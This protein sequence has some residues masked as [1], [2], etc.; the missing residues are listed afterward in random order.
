MNGAQAEK[1]AEGILEYYSL[2][3][4]IKIKYLND[5]EKPGMWGEIQN[6]NRIYGNYV[7]GFEKLTT[8]LTGGFLSNAELRGYYKLVTD[9]YYTTE[10]FS[11]E[12]VGDL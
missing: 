8:D 3:L 9:A 6:N 2:T 10:L 4:G 5:G 7:A 1:I 12:E 11:G